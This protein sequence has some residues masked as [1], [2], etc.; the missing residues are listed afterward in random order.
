[1]LGA[2]GRED[3]GG[4]HSSPNFIEILVLGNVSGRNLSLLEKKMMKENTTFDVYT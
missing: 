4:A 1:M 3:S 2:H